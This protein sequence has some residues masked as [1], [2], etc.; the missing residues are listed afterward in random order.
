MNEP[1]ISRGEL[2]EVRQLYLQVCGGD[3]GRARYEHCTEWLVGTAIASDRVAVR[4]GSRERY[5][6]LLPDGRRVVGF[7]DDVRRL[8]ALQATG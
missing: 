6:V 1:K 5:V 7:D 4:S 3:G 2:V 8:P